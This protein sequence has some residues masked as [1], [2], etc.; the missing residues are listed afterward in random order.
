MFRYALRAKV[1]FCATSSSGIALRYRPV[2]I[3]RLSRCHMRPSRA[4]LAALEKVASDRKKTIQIG[5]LLPQVLELLSKAFR[6]WFLAEVRFLYD[7]INKMPLPRSHR[8]RFG[9]S[10]DQF[11]ALVRPLSK[12][13]IMRRYR[14]RATFFMNGL[15]PVSTLCSHVLIVNGSFLYDVI[16]WKPP[17]RPSDDPCRANLRPAGG[18][19]RPPPG[20]LGPS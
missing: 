11:E 8:I 3:L 2:A 9:D 4:P 20:Q 5:T 13:R 6:G 15:K 16:D 19:L 10:T 14:I 12:I 18:H 1:V 7:V 17:P